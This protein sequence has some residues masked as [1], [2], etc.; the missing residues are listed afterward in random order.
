M[1]ALRSIMEII[2]KNQDCIPQGD[3]L[4]LCNQLKEVYQDQCEQDQFKQ[5]QNKQKG[6]WDDIMDIYTEWK[7]AVRAAMKA[8]SQ[9]NKVIKVYY[10]YS[11]DDTKRD[12]CYKMCKEYIQ[13]K[14]GVQLQIPEEYMEKTLHEICQEMINDY[15]EQAFSTYKYE[16][17]NH[18]E[19][20]TQCE[21][22]EEFLDLMSPVEMY[23]HRELCE[24][25]SETLSSVYRQKPKTVIH[26]GHYIKKEFQ[27]FSHERLFPDMDQEEEPDY[28]D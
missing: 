4:T 13:G 14:N 7:G 16:A 15:N 24:R 28:E 9:M 22:F 8:E 6:K 20:L 3:Y 2:D 25:H 23:M 19:A 12:Q 5:D 21:E 26:D 17:D 11:E 10:E 1:A 27:W 18:W